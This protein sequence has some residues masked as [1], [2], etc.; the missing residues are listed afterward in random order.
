[1]RG[2]QNNP[3]WKLSKLTKC[4]AELAMKWWLSSK[5]MNEFFNDYDY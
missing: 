4:D 5:T 1:M 2:M 3:Q